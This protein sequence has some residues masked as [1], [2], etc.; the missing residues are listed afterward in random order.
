MAT[1]KELLESIRA[2]GCALIEAAE[3][4]EGSGDETVLA[5]LDEKLWGIVDLL[6]E[7]IS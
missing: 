7:G 3:A 2:A 6:E 5:E 4:S 1:R